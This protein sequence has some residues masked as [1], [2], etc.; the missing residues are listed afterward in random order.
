ML[1]GAVRTT[2]RGDIGV[3]TNR[4]RMLRLSAL[5]LPALPPTHDAP[6]LSGGAPLAAY[7]ELPRGEEPLT[8]ASL[9]PDARPCLLYTS[10][11]V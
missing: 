8:L 4:G 10:R 9:A 2:A 1:V 11:C 7:L 5:E 3:V 6:S